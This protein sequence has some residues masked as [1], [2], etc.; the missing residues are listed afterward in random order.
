MISQSTS[1]NRG[2]ACR[3]PEG[4]VNPCTAPRSLC[5]SYSPQWAIQKKAYRYV[6][7][8]VCIHPLWRFARLLAWSWNLICWYSWS[9]LFKIMMSCTCLRNDKTAHIRSQQSR[10]ETAGELHAC[11]TTAP[12]TACENPCQGGL[13]KDCINT[14]VLEKIKN[15]YTGRVE[16]IS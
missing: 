16:M 14:F 7:V 8:P 5:N 1:E 10:A 3:R 12:D 9:S 6:R 11:E 2:K 13:L 4:E 15:G